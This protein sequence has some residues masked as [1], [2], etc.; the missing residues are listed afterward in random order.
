MKSRIQAMN[1]DF[2]KCNFCES[3]AEF[4]VRCEDLAVHFDPL[5]E[6]YVNHA[7][8]SHSL[9]PDRTYLLDEHLQLY[10]SKLFN[11]K[12]LKAKDIK[13]LINQIGR[14]GGFFSEALFEQPVELKVLME[15]ELMPALDLQ[16]KW[17]SFSDEIKEKNRFFLSEKI[18]TDE[19]QSI[20]ERLAVTYPKD[21]TFYRARISDEPLPI[22]QLG[23]PPQ[24]STTPGRANPVGIPYLYV[25]ESEKTTLYETRIALHEGITIGKFV[26][27]EPLNLVSLKNIADYGPFEIL[28]RGF[29]LEEFIQYRPYL[30]SL[31]HELSKPVRKQ[32]VH[33]DY[34][35]TQFLC[36]LI[37]SLGFD[38][39]E[40]KSAMHANGYNLAVFND[41]KLECLDA[42]FYTVKD[43]E[44][45]WG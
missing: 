39:V 17:Q 26:A 10:W 42:K 15:T 30:Q 23:K 45:K 19:L 22:A 35:P 14:G 8:N 1:W 24:K 29:S 9:N 7:E 6:L 36:E 31:E 25:S 43:L 4:I 33:L 12:L 41:E 20:F 11:T 16:L 34:L 28:D 21:T 18:D 2:G 27:K 37:K 3:E 32:D 13:H 38:A 40:Y 5:F 44:Y